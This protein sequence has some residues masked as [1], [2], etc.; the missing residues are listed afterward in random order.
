MCFQA[1]IKVFDTIVDNAPEH[2]TVIP[3]TCMQHAT[4]NAIGAVAALLN[5]VCP[6]FCLAWAFLDGSFFADFTEALF[7]VIDGK[8]EVIKATIRIF[9]SACSDFVV[10]AWH[11]AYN[12][13]CTLVFYHVHAVIRIVLMA[14]F[15]WCNY[16]LFGCPICQAS[17]QPDWRPNADDLAYSDA[18]LQSCDYQRD[19]RKSNEDTIQ[20]RKEN[21]KR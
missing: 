14:A 21:G 6:V 13:Y 11:H 15:E 18:V 9:C 5:L 12:C 20:R 2:V 10:R 3:G 1:N 4:G 7:D 19:L 8:L 16:L 17:E